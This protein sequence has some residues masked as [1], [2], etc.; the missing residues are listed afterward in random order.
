MRATPSSRGCHEADPCRARFLFVRRM[1]EKTL[2]FD[3]EKLAE[4]IDPIVRAHGGEV[5]DVEYKNERDGWVLRILVE[6]LGSAENRWNTEQA[7]VDLDLCSNVSRELSP[8]L[9]VSELIAGRY[10]L[11]VGSPG[12]ERTLR[13]PDDFR[14]FSG[15]KAK[16]KLHESIGGQKLLVGILGD[17]TAG[18]VLPVVD[19]GRTYDVPRANIERAQLV[20]EFGPAPKPGKPRPKKAAKS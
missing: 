12:V 13:T 5:Y 17:L 18:D 14:R 11:E 2:P 1:S 6:K 3:R 19:G 10:H 7:A 15:S 16:V 4:V 9:D 8:A 20:F